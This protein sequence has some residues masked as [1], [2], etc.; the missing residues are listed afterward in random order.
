MIDTVQSTK[1]S[2]SSSDVR[3]ATVGASS[4]NDVPRMLKEEAKALME[5]SDLAVIDVR[6][7]HDWETSEVKITGAVREEAKDVSSWSDKYQKDT[8]LL[9]Y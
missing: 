6:M 4:P 1:T 8:A 5:R 2:E 7:P 9:L 3:G